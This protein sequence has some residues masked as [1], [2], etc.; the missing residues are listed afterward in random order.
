MSNQM[1]VIRTVERFETDGAWRTR[2]LSTEFWV[3]G[4]QISETEAR[5]WVWGIDP[6]PA[7]IV[8][9]PEPARQM[10]EPGLHEIDPAEVGRPTRFLMKGYPIGTAAEA[11]QITADTM[12]QPQ[13]I[14]DHF[15]PQ[16]VQT[17][18]VNPN[19]D[20]PHRSV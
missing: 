4:R 7:I 18:V 14:V 10:L 11:A 12:Q 15:A 17:W 8:A 3:G 5:A 19:P 16:G 20:S 9:D 6:D 1:S 2:N 13:Y